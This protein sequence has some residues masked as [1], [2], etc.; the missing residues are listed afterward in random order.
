[1]Q[2]GLSASEAHH[3][4][5]LTMSS[6]PRRTLAERV[7]KAAEAALADHHYVSPLDVL[8]GIGWLYP[9]APGEWRQGRIEYLEKVLHVDRARIL[10][11][12][13]LLRAWASAKGLIAS[14]TQYIG[15]QPQRP[16]LRFT[17][18][19]DPAIE[20]LYRTH[21]VSGELSER[22]REQLA[23]RVSR[24]P[25]LVVIVPLNAEWKCHRCGGQGNLEQGD[26]LMMEKPDPVCLTCVGLDDLAF[27]PSGDAKLT[28]RAKAKSERSAVVVRFSRARRRYERQG[29]LVEPQALRDAQQELEREG[30]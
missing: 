13:A 23:E 12:L 5:L 7:E 6:K 19:A 18:K 25:D 3:I 21:W 27:L 4:L 24:A 10:E 9:G 14:E 16:T 22:K 20:T 1:M 15:R 30:P 11:G 17:E 26:L 8:L 29:L 28:R 2:G